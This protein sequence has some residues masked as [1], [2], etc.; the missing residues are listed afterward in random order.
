[1]NKKNVIASL[2]ILVITAN[3][4]ISAQTAGNPLGVRGQ[5][6]WTVS[7]SMN[8]TEQQMTGHQDAILRRQTAKIT[9]GML[10]WLDMYVIG[11]RT[12]LFMNN[13][14]KL[15]SDYRDKYRFMYGA[16]LSAVLKPETVRSPLQ[17]WLDV[18]GLRFIS[19]GTCDL[20]M[21]EDLGAVT[22]KKSF[23]YDWREVQCYLGLSYP[24]RQNIKLY[25]AAS[26]WALQRLD[27]Q[28]ELWN[29]NWT[30]PQKSTFQSGLWTGGQFG[31]EL[32]LPKKYSI[33]C[34]VLAFNRQNFQI[35]FGICQ[36]G[37]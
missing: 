3:G 25:L 36:T 15:I 29:E 28:K 12:Q 33:C 37:E 24:V 11:G 6:A 20:F 30:E 5:R 14:S 16:G 4:R 10:P 21:T 19:Q 27:T 18:Q 17:I 35:M 9:R 1:M 13:D 31:I 34:E 7:A 8:Y 26:V 23:E 2:V 22:W 32:L